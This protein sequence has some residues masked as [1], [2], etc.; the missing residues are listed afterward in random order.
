M[1]KKL[2]LVSAVTALLAIMASGT[3]AYFTADDV[4]HNIITTGGVDI[5][6]VEKTELPDGT[7]ADFPEEGVSGVM[8]GTVVSKIVSVQN[9]GGSEAWV[10]I[11]VESTI[12][13]VNGDKLPDTL[14]NGDPVMGFEISKNWT[15]KDGYYYYNKPVAAGDKT[16]NFIEEVVFDLL[17]GNE[18]QKCTANLIVYAEA[19]QTANNGKSA[20]E[21]LG[22]PDSIKSK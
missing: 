16:D 4:A 8:P 6:L 11:K 18:Y 19:V 2:L 14:E 5:D 7:L 12:I 9:I 17:M 22:W 13:S 21:A 1:K 3:L 10:R 15:E 20:T